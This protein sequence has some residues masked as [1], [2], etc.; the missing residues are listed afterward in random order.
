M[1]RALGIGSNTRK[2]LMGEFTQVDVK[3]LY[4][5]YRFLSSKDRSPRTR[6]VID[7]SMFPWG[8]SVHEW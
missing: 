5:I 2:R 7:A 6:K 8:H 1:M 4:G 3:R